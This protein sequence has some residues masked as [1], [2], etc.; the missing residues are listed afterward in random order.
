MIPLI[1]SL[2]FLIS[3]GIFSENFGDI[4][5]YVSV[6]FFL[7]FPFAMW[8][9]GISWMR[10]KPLR[11]F[12]AISLILPFLSVVFWWFHFVGNPYWTGAA[13]PEI[14]TAMSAI[15]WCWTINYFH[16]RGKLEE[17]VATQ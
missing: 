9:T 16:F 15:L 7:F 12:A 17:I 6:G 5:F 1:I 2:I 11:P 4:H 10:F 13:I 14:V 3:I 8:I